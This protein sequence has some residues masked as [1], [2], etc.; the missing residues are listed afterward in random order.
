VP[1]YRSA[2]AFKQALEARLG[3]G[4]TLAPLRQRVVFERFLARVSLI[5][6][7][8]A[9]VKGGLALELRLRRAR[10]T[11]DVDLR[12]A[13][14]PASVLVKLQESGR[15]DLKDFMRF[16]IQPERMLEADGMPYDGFR[17][18]AHCRLGG[19]PFGDP[20]QID[21]AFGEPF[22]GEPE[23]HPGHD[24]LGFAGIPAPQLRLYPVEAHIAEKLHAYSLPRPRPNT[25]VNDLPDIALLGTVRRLLGQ[26]L[27]AALEE[28]FRLRGTHPLP[29]LFPEPPVEPEARWELRY[30]AMVTESDLRWRSL[31][32]VVAAARA[33][34]EPVL[35]EQ[36]SS[37]AWSPDRWAWEMVEGR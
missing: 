10:T 27:R 23:V 22:F 32:E 14:A 26:T 8:A 15:L 28:T 34:L 24:W 13:G 11:K 7:H 6:G 31:P 19:R 35:L 3:Q 21:V 30:A 17:Y 5:F 29:P 9:V 25:R 36:S 37:S 2:E 18:R 20:F 33:F 12:L 1:P 4:R 16:E